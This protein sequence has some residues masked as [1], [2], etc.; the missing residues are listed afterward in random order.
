VCW[1]QKLVNRKEGALAFVEVGQRYSLAIDAEAVVMLN[2]SIWN[3]TKTLHNEGKKVT[4]ERLST[5]RQTDRQTDRHTTYRRD[6]RMAR[7]PNLITLFQV[8][9]LPQGTVDSRWMLVTPWRVCKIPFHVSRIA[10]LRK[11]W[12]GLTHLFIL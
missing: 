10:C 12:P 6:R 7:R 9:M 8:Q 3:A 4:G 2:V 1:F 11:L 5:D